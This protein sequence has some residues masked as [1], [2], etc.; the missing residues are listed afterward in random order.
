MADSKHNHRFVE[1]DWDSVPNLTCFTHGAMGGTFQ[2][3]IQHQDEDFAR[4]C[5]KA[6]FDEVDR[7]EG[8]LSRYIENSDISRIN[9]LAAG[10]SVVV[11]L[12]TFRCLQLSA[13]V[14]KQT[15][16]AFD[17]TIGPILDFWRNKNKRGLSAEKLDLARRRAAMHLLKL[18]ESRYT[19]QVPVAN[20]RVDLGGIGK[21]YAADV[22]AQVLR[23]WRAEVALL[24]GG[25]SSVLALGKPPDTKGWP[26]TLSNPQE[27]KETLARVYLNHQALGASGVQKGSHIIDPRTARPVKATL[28]A[29]VRCHRAAVADAL[30]TA[31]M[32]MSPTEIEHYCSQHPDVSAL[33]IFKDD[34]E[35]RTK[36]RIK[37]YGRWQ[38]HELTEYPPS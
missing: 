32:V 1:S 28:A 6:A 14:N 24:S 30:S 26:V 27:P 11:D 31:F 5:A 10:G 25:Y 36:S 2:L 3:F 4:K 13:E 8:L 9:N 33:V 35:P 21:G 7:L 17:V 12:D 34:D 22:V 18:D 19:V 15:G 16:G 23:Q 29:W 37:H 38:A 20:I